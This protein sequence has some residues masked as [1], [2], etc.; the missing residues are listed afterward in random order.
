[1]SQRYI[2]DDEL[3]S[4]L[5]PMTDE[6]MTDEQRARLKVRIQKFRAER[7]ERQAWTAVWADQAVPK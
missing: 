2:S 4:A 7:A 1:M 5:P 6:P 3:R